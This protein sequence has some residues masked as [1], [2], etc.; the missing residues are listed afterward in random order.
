VLVAERLDPAASSAGL[1]R[2]SPWD[3]FQVAYFAGSTMP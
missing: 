1:T 2:Q 3:D